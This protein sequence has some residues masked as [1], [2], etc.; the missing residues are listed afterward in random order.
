MGQVILLSFTAAANPT[1]IAVS[2][3]MLLLPN[4]KRLMLGYLCGAMLTSVTL[5]LL[6][7]FAI[8]R[9]AAVKT[10]QH[11]LSPVAD[12]ALG[13]L[14]LLLAFVLGT[15]RD[16][17]I[18]SWRAQKHPKKE[19]GPPRWQRVLSNG[20]PRMTFLV[21]AFLTLPGASYLV[22][23]HEI[24]TLNYAPAPTV[25]L[26]L[27]FNAVMLMLLEIPLVGFVVAPEWT[28]V[29]I[30]RAKGWAREHWHRFAFV[31]LLVVGAAL[32]IKGVIGLLS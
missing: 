29:A 1:L 26:V 13:A 2:T 28:P 17:R 11:T 21:G 31:G 25:L 27:Y 12:L 5:G 4:P 6:I 15:G 32:L 9:S 10:T 7:V 30:D 14:C 18:E 20:S 19:K 3:L 24:K 22:G 23:L 16:R 8:N